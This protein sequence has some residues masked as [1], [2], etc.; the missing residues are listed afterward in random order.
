MKILNPVT[1][2][3]ESSSLQPECVCPRMRIRRTPNF[4]ASAGAGIFKSLLRWILGPILGLIA[5]VLDGFQRFTVW[6]LLFEGS[7]R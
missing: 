2:A 6:L 3:A 5:K 7:V 1:L 4:I